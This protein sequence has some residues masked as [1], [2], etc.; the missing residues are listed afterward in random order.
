MQPKVQFLAT[1]R[2]VLETIG[3]QQLDAGLD[4]Q[5]NRDFPPGSPVFE[6]IREACRAGAEDGWMQLQGDASRRGARVIEPAA[7]SAG[8]SVDVVELAD[9]VGPHHRHPGGEICA[10]L[11]VTAG[12]RF[13]G[14][15]EGWTV[16]PPGSE[17]WPS[18]E[19]GRLRVMFF[20]PGGVIEYTDRVASLGSGSASE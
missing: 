7:E 19:G 2:P 10:V 4:V 16:Y 11:P 6:D 13:D 12:A 5:L 20:L 14:R 17:H 8:L 15:G 1:L 3:S 9:I 18:A